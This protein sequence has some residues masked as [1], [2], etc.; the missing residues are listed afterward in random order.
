MKKV[1]LGVFYTLQGLGNLV[2]GLFFV[3]G[4]LGGGGFAMEIIIRSFLVFVSCLSL[5]TSLTLFLRLEKWAQTSGKVSSVLFGAFY[6]WM[7]FI[8]YS[9]IARQYYI[10]AVLWLLISIVIVALN[11]VSII[12]MRI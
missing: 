10:N 5:F 4:G 3:S 12:S 9:E 1:L 8:S 2:L 6:V 7:A 11:V